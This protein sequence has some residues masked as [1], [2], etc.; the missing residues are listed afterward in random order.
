MKIIKMLGVLTA[1]IMAFAVC[2]L[3]AGE[4]NS[5]TPPANEV[6][7]F[8]CNFINF[9]F[10]NVLDIYAKLTGV[11]LKNDGQIPSA[12]I[13]FATAKPL[14]HSE[15]IQALEKVLREQ[16]GIVLKPL[17]AKHVE[18]TYDESVKLIN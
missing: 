18:V 7:G 4:T 15:A 9:P 6:T 1:A 5:A 17:D 16:A 3:T 8:T 13:N 10:S 11:E 12:E 14:T 2:N